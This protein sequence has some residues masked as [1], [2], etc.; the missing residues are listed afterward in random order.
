MHTG[1]VHVFSVKKEDSYLFFVAQS[2]LRMN[3]DTL[4]A[5][6]VVG[7]GLEMAEMR[8]TFYC[9][10]YKG[11]KG[12]L[13]TTRRVFHWSA[14]LLSLEHFNQLANRCRHWAKSVSR[15]YLELIM[16]KFRNRPRR[17]P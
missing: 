13:L 7:E 9:A 8:T 15:S 2:C 3:M 5:S 6:F 11:G 1:L 12:C 4:A 16:A 17:V 10:K 14:M